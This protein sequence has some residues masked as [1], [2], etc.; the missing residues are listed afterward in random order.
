MCVCNG[1]R[2]RRN[3]CQGIYID[4]GKLFSMNN[5]LQAFFFMR[6]D[7]RFICVQVHGTESI[8]KTVHWDLISCIVIVFFLLTNKALY[9]KQSKRGISVLFDASSLYR[10][11]CLSHFFLRCNMLRSY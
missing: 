4:A 7:T 9:Y 3:C 10:K 11:E 6:K 5:T 1:K 2:Y 8:L